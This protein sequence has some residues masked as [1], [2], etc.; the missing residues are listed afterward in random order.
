MA[1]K[2]K[3]IF[4]PGSNDPTP[5]PIPQLPIP[6][7]FTSPLL[8]SPTVKNVHFASNPCR[9]NFHGKTCVFY[10]RPGLS[11]SLSSS[12]LIPPS[13][14]TGNLQ[15]TFKT[16]L[17]Q[18]HLSPLPLSSSP[19]YWDLDPYLRLSPPPSGLILGSSTSAGDGGSAAGGAL[20]YSPEE[21]KEGTYCVETGRFDLEKG[22]FVCYY[23]E[24]G[25]AEF[26]AVG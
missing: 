23:P 19:I 16:I 10:N 26:S 2:A 1:S 8:N 14:G 13:P 5:S 21:D 3:F 6:N 24:T 25:E 22:D 18:S 11:Q 15:H 7:F 9:I 20:H 12:S 17:D 4:V